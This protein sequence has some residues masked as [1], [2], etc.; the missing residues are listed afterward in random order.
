MK[1]SVTNKTVVER[2]DALVNSADLDEL[3]V[4]CTPDM[5]NHAL[6]PNRPAGLA[7]TREF[8][9]TADR[10]RS[11]GWRDHVVV[12]EGDY[13]VQYGVR[14]G[15]WPGGPFL[16]ISAPPGPYARG[17]AFMYRLVAGRI[18]ERW[19]IRDDLGM[20]RQLGAISPP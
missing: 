1:P 14:G 9:R 18:A 7:G 12:A 11:D 4:L 13:V 19:A 10:F 17:T 20:L 6:A 2:F 16:G 3:D 15:D 8:L 5:I